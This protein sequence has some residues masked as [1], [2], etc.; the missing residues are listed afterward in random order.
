LKASSCGRR[1]PAKGGKRCVGGMVRC[2]TEEHRS[3]LGGVVEM[4][5]GG[6]RNEGSERNGRNSL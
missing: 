5:G 3:C 4:F 2:M 1:S 6:E